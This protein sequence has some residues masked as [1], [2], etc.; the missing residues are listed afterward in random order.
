MAILPLGTRNHLAR[1]M[2]V[3]L[4]LEGAAEVAVNGQRRRIDL[5]G[6][7]GRVFIN[8]ASFGLYTR[9]VHQR[10]SGEGP[11]WLKSIPATWHV[12]RH[13]RAQHFPLR[14]DGQ[15]RSL[16]TP[17]LFIGNNRYSLEAGRFGER[18]S[19]ADGELSICAVSARLPRQLIGFA[20]RALVGL[21]DPARDFEMMSSAREIV[22]EGSGVIEGAFDGELEVLPL[23]LTIRTMPGA[24]GIVTPREAAGGA[25]PAEAAD[26]MWLNRTH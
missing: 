21:A 24:L 16:A 20:L 9:F 23:P 14:I 26:R 6:A 15:M 4:D 19:M 3:P 2:G 5:G 7:G 13:M 17:L 11:K 10:D 8:N 18:E 25:A 12:L 22:I 1:Q